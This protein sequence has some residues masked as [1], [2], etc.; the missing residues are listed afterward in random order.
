MDRPVP[1]SF[2]LSDVFEFISSIDQ[3]DAIKTLGV[4]QLHDFTRVTPEFFHYLF[5][6]GLLGDFRGTCKKCKTGD[7]AL[8]RDGC[9][10]GNGKS[11]YFWRCRNR[12]CRRKFTMRHKSFFEGSHLEERD[13]ILLTCCW[14][15]RYPQYCVELK[16]QHLGS[17]T[18][19]DWYNFCRGVCEQ[20]LI[21]DNKKIG[22]PG[23][24]VEVDESKF[25]K[26]K[27]N[28]G[29]DVEG[30]WVF[31]GIDRETRETFF[32][33]VKKRNAETLISALKEHVLP[34]TTIISDCW[35]GYGKVKDHDFKHFTVNHSVNF[36]D[37]NDPTVHTNTI[38]SQWRVLKRSVLPRF[39][40]QKSLYESYFAEYCI[41][42]RYIENSVC[43]F[44]AFVQL[45]KR[46]YPLKAS[47]LYLPIPSNVRPS[48]VRPSS[49]RSSANDARPST[50]RKM[51]SPPPSNVRPSSSR[52]SAT[53]ARP[54]TSRKSSSP[55]HNPPPQKRLKDQEPED[56]GFSDYEI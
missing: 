32:K 38:E 37:P 42:K 31:G 7:V 22:G 19:V 1:Y 48:N 47:P 56:F 34:G 21:L 14:V 5:R 9:N 24:I 17:H 36:V 51:S 43:P 18:L 39:G 3:L 41:R 46:V 54:S 13:I 30:T 2:S 44:R 29:H 10:V 8:M 15:H 35:K 20:I 4:L 12:K 40:T 33:V 26:R 50:S 55:P 53:D 11:N 49:S 28:I 23:H 27:Y 25:G 45:I 52:S 6:E 16:T